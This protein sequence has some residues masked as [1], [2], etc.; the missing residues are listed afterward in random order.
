[1]L[2]V[3]MQNRSAR[4]QATRRAQ[5]RERQIRAFAQRLG[6]GIAFMGIAALYGAAIVGF[7]NF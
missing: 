7:W 4:I 6:T 2:N 5:Q 1:M 3:Y